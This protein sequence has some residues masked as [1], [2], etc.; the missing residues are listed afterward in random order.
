MG[1]YHTS[2]KPIYFEIHVG[3]RDAVQYNI[4][5]EIVDL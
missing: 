2:D 4:Y 5:L 1:G 3:D